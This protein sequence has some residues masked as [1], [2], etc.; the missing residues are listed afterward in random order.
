MK[1]T[2]LD[3]ISHSIETHRKKLG[4]TQ[5]QLAEK[6]S[7]NRATIG[8]I[9]KKEY[10]PS[11]DQLQNLTFALNIDITDLFVEENAPPK[12]IPSSKSYNIAVAGTGY[13]G[14][15]LAVLLSQH[16]H[17]TAVDTIPE[18]VEML[19]KHVSPIQDD[20]I[21]K[22]LA[23]EKLNLTATL[24]AESAYANADFVIIAA[25]TNYD[26]KLNFFD[27]ST[28]ENVIELVLKFNPNAMMI[29]KST[30]PV[31]YTESV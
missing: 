17:V 20:Y 24:D 18:E 29:I 12:D 11:I 26:S 4:L 13:V 5:A 31:G 25:P 14:L 3:I 21:E 15:S 19:N 28:V 1:K 16:N 10:M 8:R 30:I 23:E 22:Y 27:C 6:S 7:L 2:S 9:E